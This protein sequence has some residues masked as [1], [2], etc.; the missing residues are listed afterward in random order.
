MDSG[1][2]DQTVDLTAPTG[3]DGAAYTN[4]RVA[5]PFAVLDAI[6]NGILLVLAEDPNANFAPLDV[7]WSPANS[8]TIGSGTFDERV[9]SGE[10]GTSFYSGDRLFLLGMD[11]DDAEEFDDHV[12]VHEWGHYFKSL[13]IT[14]SCTNGDI[15]SKIIF[16]AR[17]AP[18]V[19]TASATCSTC[20][21][22][23]AKD[24][25]LHCRGWRSTIR[26]IVTPCGSAAT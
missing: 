26:A 20:E 7:F 9:D 19:R 17:T 16:L 21:S 1:M 4:P 3:W 25:P 14:S 8:T 2:I 15:T 5:A 18:A 23:S 22:H 24:S 13:T 6:Y 12:I 11:G 10:L